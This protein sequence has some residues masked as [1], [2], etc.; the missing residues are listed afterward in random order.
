MDKAAG[1]RR[2]FQRL[3]GARSARRP[4]AEIVQRQTNRHNRVM[5]EVCPPFLNG[6]WIVWTDAVPVKVNPRGG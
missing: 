4:V 3:M 2:L 5:Y 1:L 6:L